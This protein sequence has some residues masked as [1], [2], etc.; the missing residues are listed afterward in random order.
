LFL[1]D[2]LKFTT[3]DNPWKNSFDHYLKKST[4]A[5]LK[6]IFDAHGGCLDGDSVKT[7]ILHI[8]V[9]PVRGESPLLCIDQFVKFD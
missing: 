3:V 5:L 4:V 9:L 6:N 2:K 7:L 1:G 8:A